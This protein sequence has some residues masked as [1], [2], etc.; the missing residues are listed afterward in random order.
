MPNI[1]ISGLPLATL[2]LDGPNSFF[3]VQTIEAGVTVSRKVASDDLTVGTGIAVEDEGVPLAAAATTLDFVG[4]GVT[5][6]GAGATKTITIPGASGAVVN[7][8]TVEGQMLRWDNTGSDYDP[9]SELI[10]DL[11]GFELVSQLTYVA[12]GG[13]AI[14]NA[15]GDVFIDNNLLGGGQYQYSVNLGNDVIRIRDDGL[16]LFGMSG[17]TQLTTL[18]SGAEVDIIR[19]GVDQVALTLAPAAGGLSVNNTL[20]GG[21]LER[22][23]TLSDLGGQVD[24]VVGGTNISVNVADPVN[25]IVNLDAAITGVSVNAVTLT[26][27]GVATNYLDETGAYSVPAGGGGG[28]PTNATYVVISLD[29]TLTDERVLTSGNGISL[30]DGGAGGNATIDVDQTFNFVFSGSVEFTNVLGVEFGPSC[31]LD[32]RN[33]TDNSATF[34]Q[35]LGSSI[36]FGVAGADFGS[37]IF[38]ISQSSFQ[39]VNCPPL[40]IGEQAAAEADVGGDGQVWVRNNTPNNLMFTDDAGNDFG[41]AYATGRETANATHDFNTAG[42][43]AENFIGFYDDGNPYTV[44]LED[45]TSVVNW[46]LNTAIQVLA[47]TVGAITVD[48]GAGTTLFLDDGTDTVGGGT[49]TQGVVTIYRTSTTDYYIWGSGFTP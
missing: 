9:F 4:A 8:G 17:G 43:I 12:E 45:S 21:G 47:P 34:I 29:A 40:F 35:N 13:I 27:A 31:E 37:Q 44:T 22:V 46:P 11:I 38:D 10:A 3:E 19:N 7:P 23:L 41:V 16:A 30:T 24:S 2:P 6:S 5:A 42:N 25:P 48:E 33:P 18:Q 14:R 26:A 49:L 15:N 1:T 39:Q 20:T 36:Q 32:L 28:A